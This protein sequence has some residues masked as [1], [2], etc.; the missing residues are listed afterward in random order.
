MSDRRLRFARYAVPLAVAWGAAVPAAGQE[1]APTPAPA[2]RAVAPLTTPGSEPDDRERTA[3][4]LG[5][6][7]LA[8]YLVRST[9]SRTPAP[10]D[11][12]RIRLGLVGPELATAWNSRL[13]WSQN[14]AAVWAGRGLTTSVTGGFRLESGRVSLVVA[15]QVGFAQNR[16]LAGLPP[17]L[18]ESGGLVLPWYGGST[19]ADLPLRFGDEGIT[20]VDPGQSALTVRAG[21]AAFG[22]STESLWWGP[23]IRNA[24]V[25]SDNAPGIPHLF[26]RTG[27]PLSTPLGRFEARWMIGAL[28]ES[29]YFD[30]I[31]SNDVRSLSGL[32]AT[33]TPRGEPGLTLGA[34]RT[35]QATV[36]G[37]GS[38]LPRAGDVFFRWGGT[39]A[40]DSADFEQITSLFGRWVFPDDGV[41]V[42][43]EWART[44]MPR[45]LGDF[46]DYPNHSQGY[47]LGLQW[48]RRMRAESALRL[49]GEVTY[50]EQ[51]ASF[52]MRDV[53]RYYTS[54]VVPQG[55]THR[56]QV[57]GAAIGPG[58]SS[59]WLAAD[60]LAGGWRV[61][62]FGGRTRW[63]ND[64][65]Y[66]YTPPWGFLGHDVS[67]YGGVRGSYAFAGL[68]L[69]AELTRGNRFNF[70]YQNRGRS[71]ETAD[72]AVDVTN[73]SLR[74]TLS[75][76]ARA[77]RPAPAAAPPPPPPTVR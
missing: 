21:G 49:H 41:E 33:F 17:A 53:K 15:P 62:L 40:A 10:A 77:S 3:Q 37:T 23:G 18:V 1:P 8:G 61:G 76:A 54:H 71:W 24:L 72:D 56:G 30:T 59:Q 69:D 29:E 48:A 52:R 60:Y 38:V 34:A 58:A 73:H 68:R 66:G 7:P 9:W 75:P 19:S 27:S 13:P 70:L 2:S 65:F 25:M 35:V 16:A 20:F 26:L 64:A 4:L 67:V 45:S 46:L 14:D 22:A 11:G 5:D 32:A 39:A 44:E 55:Y 47:T 31:S 63:D 57:I 51:S 12:S 28:A 43:G 6:A 50:L 36:D 74:L 42:Y